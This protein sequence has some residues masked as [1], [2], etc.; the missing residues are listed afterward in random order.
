MDLKEHEVSAVSWRRIHGWSCLASRSFFYEHV[1]SV[2]LTLEEGL[3]SPSFFLKHRKHDQRNETGRSASA[4]TWA[5][6]R[7]N[8]CTY[9]FQPPFAARW[10]WWLWWTLL[11]SWILPCVAAIS[12]WRMPLCPHFWPSIGG[13]D[14]ISSVLPRRSKRQNF[15]GR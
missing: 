3:D 8:T 15:L 2:G 5:N 14:P 6:D 12:Q 9:S 4:K 11:F 1:L 10:S 7:Q 13:N